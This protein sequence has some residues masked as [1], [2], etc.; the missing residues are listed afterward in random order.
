MPDITIYNYCAPPYY[1]LKCSKLPL[2]QKYLDEGNNSDAPGN[3]I[4]Y[5]TISKEVKAFVFEGKRYDI[6]TI[7]SYNKVR[8][9]FSK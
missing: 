2:I 8:E 5:L 7:E 3:F 6:G 9:I 4:P 1:V